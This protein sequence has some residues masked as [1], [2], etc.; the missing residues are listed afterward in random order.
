MI[1]ITLYARLVKKLVFFFILDFTSLSIDPFQNRKITNVGE[2]C[3]CH[4]TKWLY[5]VRN[6]TLFTT[7]RV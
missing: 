2:K 6:Q 4:G 7:K 3:L 1:G 5:A